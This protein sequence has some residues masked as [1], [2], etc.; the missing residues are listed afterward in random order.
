MKLIESGLETLFQVFS[1]E[2]WGILLI[3]VRL[4]TQP[5]GDYITLF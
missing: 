2:Y 4:G 3:F 1:G 5:K